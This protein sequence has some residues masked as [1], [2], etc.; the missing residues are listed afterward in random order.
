MPAPKRTKEQ[1]LKLIDKELSLAVKTLRLEGWS[2]EWRL[3]T[4]A[5]MDG[6]DADAETS[7][8]PGYRRA[9]IVFSEA[10]MLKMTAQ[11][12]RQI[13]WH[14]AGHLFLAQ[15][16][17]SIKRVLGEGSASAEL[18]AALETTIDTVVNTIYPL[19]N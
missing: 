4:A 1:L 8:P 9:D 12:A 14:E 15:I 3:G 7:W 5:E 10:G 18:V 17:D 2:L 6:K 11:E 19:T 16:D 13:V